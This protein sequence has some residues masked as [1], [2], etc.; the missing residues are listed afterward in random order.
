MYLEVIVV[1]IAILVIQYFWNRYQISKIQ[2]KHNL[3]KYKHRKRHHNKRRSKQKR[4]HYKRK[5]KHV[6]K[7]DIVFMDIVTDQEHLGKIHIKLFSNVVPYTCE[8]FKKLCTSKDRNMSYVGSPFHRIIKGFMIQGGDFTKGNG[9]GGLSIYGEKFPDENFAISHDRK[10]LLSMANSGPD[11]NGSQ[12][13][14]TT[15]ET[16]HLDGKHVVFGEIVKGYHVV[17]KIEKLK[18]DHNDRPFHECT[19]KR[20]GLVK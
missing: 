4:K 11:T 2:T 15:S 16:P 19:I 9:T 20:C 14:I 13:F 12:F 8:N 6:P 10:G 3:K 5:V 18:T 7:D 17:K 1:I